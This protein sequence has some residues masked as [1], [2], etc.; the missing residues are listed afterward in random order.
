MPIYLL[1]YFTDLGNDRVPFSYIA[2]IYRT[3][4]DTILHPC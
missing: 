1:I 4:S 2:V 3:I